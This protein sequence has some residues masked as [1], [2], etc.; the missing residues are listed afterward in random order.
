MAAEGLFFTGQVLKN[1]RDLLEEENARQQLKLQNEQLDLQREE[2]IKARK[3]ARAQNEKSLYTSLSIKGAERY[4]DYFSTRQTAIDDY[5]RENSDLIIDKPNSEEAIALKAMQDSFRADVNS[6]VRRGQLL[7]TYDKSKIENKTN[8]YKIDENGNFVYEV[9]ENQ[10]IDSLN[11]GADFQQSLSDYNIGIDNIIKKSESNPVLEVINNESFGY[12]RSERIDVKSG[13]TFTE[14]TEQTKQEMANQVFKG[15]TVNKRGSWDNNKFQELY[16]NGTVLVVEED[17]SKSK[18]SAINVFFEEEYNNSSPES[19]LIETL[20]PTIDGNVNESFDPELSN[21]YAQWL[22]NRKIEEETAGSSTSKKSAQAKESKVKEMTPKF[23]EM[24]DQE[25]GDDVYTEDASR[26]GIFLNPK[27]SDAPKSPIKTE[28]NLGMLGSENNENKLA[29]EAEVMRLKYPV[30]STYEKDKG[31]L[32][33]INE[34]PNPTQ[35][36]IKSKE[37][38]EGR[39]KQ[40]RRK[41]LE[42]KVLRYTMTR[43]RVPV[44]VVQVSS[45]SEI[46]VPLSMLKSLIGT[47]YK[48]TRDEEPTLGYY[49]FLEAGASPISEKTVSAGNFNFS[50]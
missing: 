39:I 17:G 9:S 19:R 3:D 50:R 35:R 25:Y 15:L 18:V 34:L 33:K 6:A 44:A 41:S 23:R 22:S 26:N 48:G 12:E 8:S 43:D 32:D 40:A 27:V 49:L 36:Q 7:N 1:S 28:I 2:K 24:F 11:S 47:T 46:I 31:E 21:Q 42:V 5:T 4:S 45:G 30:G 29:F 14:Y 10:F 37:E 38:I 20:M 16:K 13:L